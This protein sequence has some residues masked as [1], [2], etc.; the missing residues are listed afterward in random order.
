MVMEKGIRDG[1][2]TENQHIENVLFISG[3]LPGQEV[4]ALNTVSS[5][6]G[7]DNCG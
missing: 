4:D 1:G 3:T 7:I 6:G 5:L 2:N